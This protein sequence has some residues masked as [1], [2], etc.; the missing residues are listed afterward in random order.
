MSSV[1]ESATVQSGPG[2]WGGRTG[3]H[4]GEK[5]LVPPVADIIE[6]SCHAEPAN[7]LC[8]FGANHVGNSAHVYRGSCERLTNQL[9]VYFDRGAGLN[10][11]RRKKENTAGAD[12]C[13]LQRVCLRVTLSGYPL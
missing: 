2:R 9:N 5:I 6:S 12:I 13:R 4:F 7:L 1:G 8:R 11:K 10:A 3:R